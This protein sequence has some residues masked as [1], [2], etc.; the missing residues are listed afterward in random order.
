[1]MNEKKRNCRRKTNGRLVKKNHLGVEIK[2]SKWVFCNYFMFY[3]KEVKFL[4]KSRHK[5]MQSV[6]NVG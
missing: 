4:T 5:V 6:K 3:R 1:M 2:V